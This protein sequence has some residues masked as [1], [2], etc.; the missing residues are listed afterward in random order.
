MPTNPSIDRPII[1]MPLQPLGATD[2]YSYANGVVAWYS[3]GFCHIVA[4]VSDPIVHQDPA[5]T[6]PR[7]QLATI[8]AV[9][10]SYGLSEDEAGLLAEAIERYAR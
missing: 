10:R 5:I 2:L 9:A 3:P 6:I 8:I 1:P 7:T 4:V